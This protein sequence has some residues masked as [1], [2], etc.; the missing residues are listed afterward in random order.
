MDGIEATVPIH[1]Q[2]LPVSGLLQFRENW[3]GNIGEFLLK[4]VTLSRHGL[5]ASTE[6]ETL[7]FLFLD[8]IRFKFQAAAHGLSTTT[9]RSALPV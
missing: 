4:I 6:L 7:L 1:K 8:S 5:K 2:S 9:T 3:V